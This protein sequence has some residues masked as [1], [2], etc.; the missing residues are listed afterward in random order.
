VTRVFCLACGADADGCE[1][2]AP[3]P[4]L[5]EST[6]ARTFAEIGAERL[7]L[8]AKLSAARLRILAD[9]CGQPA[10]AYLLRFEAVRLDRARGVRL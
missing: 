3:L 1:P 8:Q 9:E 7:E 4:R 5:P 10:V 6:E 2:D